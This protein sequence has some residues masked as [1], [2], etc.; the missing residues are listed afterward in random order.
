MYSPD[1]VP[2]PPSFAATHQDLPSHVR[3]LHTQRDSGKAV[4]NT[5]ALFACSEREAREAIALN[6]GAISLA[7]WNRLGLL[8]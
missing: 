7:R 1:E 4:K 3:W 8:S 2:L 6:Y 5:Q